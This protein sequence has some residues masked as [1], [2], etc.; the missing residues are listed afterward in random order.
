MGM[1]DKET[2]LKNATEFDAQQPFELFEAEYI[3]MVNSAQY[4]KN[5]KAKV[6]AGP[7]DSV[8]NAAKEYVVFGVMAEQIG[9][10]SD[11]DLPATVKIGK[12][13]QA[14][15]LVRAE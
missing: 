14:N 1:F 2:Q 7:K 3:G 11:D 12:D 9:R 15:V 8:P 6:K 5:Q 10:M 4:G 13:G